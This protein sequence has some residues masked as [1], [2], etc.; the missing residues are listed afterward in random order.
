MCQSFYHLSVHTIFISFFCFLGFFGG[1]LNKQKKADHKRSKWPEIPHLCI[2]K[3][4][5]HTL[6]VPKANKLSSSKTAYL[7][8]TL[9]TGIKTLKVSV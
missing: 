2:D 9:N 7:E 8:V 4:I 5:L 1:F 3:L 6:I